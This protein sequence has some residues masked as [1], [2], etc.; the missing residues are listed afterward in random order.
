[1]KVLGSIA[2]P[3]SEVQRPSQPQLQQP[4]RFHVIQMPRSQ[5]RPEHSKEYGR[6]CFS[7]AFSSTHSVMPGELQKKCSS[8]LTNYS[9]VFLD[10]Y[11]LYIHII[12]VFP[13]VFPE[14]GVTR[15]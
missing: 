2:E 4:S 10:W 7:S 5:K 13:F 9:D 8:I 11:V 15:M 3:N 12:P 14:R 1:M 6:T